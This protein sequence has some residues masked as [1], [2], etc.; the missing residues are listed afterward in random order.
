MRKKLTGPDA[1]ALM[2]VVRGAMV[3]A[4]L[5]ARLKQGRFSKV[6]EAPV[7]FF[8]AAPEKKSAEVGV[9]SSEQDD[10]AAA[11]RAESERRKQEAEAAERRARAI[12]EAEADAQRLASDADAA[13]KAAK[14][15]RRRADEAEEEVRALKAAK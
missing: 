3:D 14:T 6:P 7:G 2:A 12:A 11:M 10:V 9:R 4:E 8:G 13:E 1:P 5:A 15:A